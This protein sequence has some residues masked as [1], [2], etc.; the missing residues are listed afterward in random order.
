MSIL[1]TADGKITNAMATVPVI[2]DIHHI[3]IGVGSANNFQDSFIRFINLSNSSGTVTIEGV[4]E[5]GF[6]NGSQ[7]VLSLGP[8]QS[9]QLTVDDLEFGNPNKGLSGSLGATADTWR[10]EATPSSTV[11]LRV[12]NMMR[13]PDGFLTDLGVSI[14]AT[15]VSSLTGRWHGEYVCAQGLTRLTLDIDAEDPFNIDAIFRFREHED[16]PGVPSGSF[17]MEGSFDAATGALDLDATDWI[18]Q[19][20]NFLTVDLSGLLSSREERISGEV[21]NA[22]CS[23]F[24]V[25]KDAIP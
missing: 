23:T 19:P 13:T 1:Q 14:P 12:M 22:A 20:T 7:A 11:S 17:A 16:N 25:V 5:N 2:D 3:L 4:R 8:R 21:S 6:R 18:N 15:N 9:Q 24:S 10:L